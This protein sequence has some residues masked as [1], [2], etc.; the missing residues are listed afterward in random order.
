[1]SNDGKQGGVLKGKTHNEGGMDAV[2]TN[3]GN[4]AIEVETEEVILTAPAMKS[5]A[6]VIC[7]GTPKGVAS[8]INEHGGG[9]KFSDEGNCKVV[10]EKGTSTSSV[11]GKTSPSTNATFDGGG[12]LNDKWK[13]HAKWEQLVNMTASE[14]SEFYD[15]EEGKQAGLSASEAKELGIHSSR[16]SARW[17][18]KMKATPESEWTPEM[19]DW[20]KR[21]ISFISRMQG[22]KGPLYDDKGNKTRK[23]IALLIWGHDPEKMGQG[24]NLEEITNTEIVGAKNNSSTLNNNKMEKYYYLEH[25]SFLRESDGL[26]FQ[27]ISHGRDALMVKPYSEIDKNTE[28]MPIEYDHLINLLDTKKVIFEGKPY[29]SE[30]DILLLLNEIGKIKINFAISDVEQTL[31]ETQRNLNETRQENDKFHYGQS[32][33]GRMEI[34]RKKLENGGMLVA[35]EI[36]NQLGGKALYMLGARNLAGDEKSLQFDIRGSKRF[37]RI[38]IQLNS[39]DLYDI[40]FY[41]IVKFDIKDMKTVNDVYVDQ[42]HN[43]IEKETGLYTQ[44]KKGGEINNQFQGAFSDELWKSHIIQDYLDSMGNHPHGWIGASER[45]NEYDALIENTF[46]NKGLSKNK[47]AEFL[48]S[49][50][51]R[52]LAPTLSNEKAPAIV[53]EWAE[54]M[55]NRKT[56]ADGGYISAAPQPFFAQLNL[57]ALPSGAAQY[58]TDEII[59]DAAL[60]DLPED[61]EAFQAVSSLIQENYHQSLLPPYAEVVDNEESGELTPALAEQRLKVLNKLLAKDPEN[62]DLGYRHEFMERRKAGGPIVKGELAQRYYQALEELQRVGS[63]LWKGKFKGEK[64][65]RQAYEQLGEIYA[66][67]IIELNDKF[68]KGGGIRTKN[69]SIDE[70]DFM[71]YSKDGLRI[72]QGTSLEDAKEFAEKRYGTKIINQYEGKRAEQ[73]WDAWT[74]D[75]KRHFLVDHQEDWTGKTLAD[76]SM[77]E[78]VEYMKNSDFDYKALPDKLK[79]M[80]ETHV[81]MG[82]YKTGGSIPNNYKDKT[83][84]QVWDAW[85]ASQK[86]HFIEDHTGKQHTPSSIFEFTKKKFK[87]LPV[88]IKLALYKHLHTGQYKSGGLIKGYD[89]MFA[90]LGNGLTVV[91]RA[92][93]VKG[94]Y[95]KLAHISEQ[96]KITIYKNNLPA[97]V[98]DKIQDEAAQ[99][100]EG[101][102]QKES[103]GDLKK[104]YQVEGRR[105]K[106]SPWQPI[107]NGLMTKEEAEK[108]KEEKKDEYYELNVDV[109]LPFD[110]GTH[111]AISEKDGYWFIMSKPTSKEKAQEAIDLGV[112]KGEIGKVVTVEEA[113]KHKKIIGRE[114]LMKQGGNLEKQKLKYAKQDIALLEKEGAMAIT[115][116]QY[117]TLWGNYADGVFSFDTQHGIET[118][119]RF[120]G[121]KQEA[122]EFVKNAYTHEYKKGGRISQANQEIINNE[123]LNRGAPLKGSLGKVIG[124]KQTDKGLFIITSSGQELPFHEV[125]VDEDKVYA[126]GGDLRSLCPVGTQIQTLVFNK[127]QFPFKLHAVKWS[128]QHRF[129]HNKVDIEKNTFRLRQQSPKN[130][131]KKEGLKTITLTK[132][133]QAV[134]G[135]PTSAALNRQAKDS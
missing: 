118:A 45:S 68:A 7:E 94:D 11:P 108:L 73:I 116:T 67:N 64:K 102:D 81:E 38:K 107:H 59:T 123:G 16:E 129:K 25:G 101:N 119:N 83:A 36:R 4:R 125:E 134:V 124:W 43:V 39:K 127:K 23:H 51:A 30:R 109:P 133:V 61:N 96:G 31:S 53:E 34:L 86:T 48:I 44:L 56:M 8:A 27:I 135:C 62:A 40:T 93:E 95:E 35:N 100:R 10:K 26:R 71:V 66:D 13:V 47:I 49:S 111:V 91:N 6:H 33:P 121:N 117:G 75:Q 76:S 97:E 54:T 72:Y 2:V 131:R 90:S 55:S 50:D 21:Q 79:G 98:K 104:I 58:I 63:A 22:V 92:R 88:H 82:R 18:L 78:D 1:M 77:E 15:S 126:S 110:N 24:G 19:W 41:K 87:F 114:Y 105:D 69:Y 128:K 57:I 37:N 29:E 32:L 42:L 85:D 5:E 80:I 112:P 14:L 65:F 122:I 74:R 84:E 106:D 20:A 60:A 52:H 46:T 70:N 113:R 130:F 99:M 28:E 120:T 115:D 89:L 9:V 132:G 12:D 3:D 103:G 17:I